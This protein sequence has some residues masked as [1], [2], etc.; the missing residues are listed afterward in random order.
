MLL[1]RAFYVRDRQTGVVSLYHLLTNYRLLL[2]FYIPTGPHIL[3]LGGGH[4]SVRRSLYT[5]GSLLYMQ[6]FDPKL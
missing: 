5:I 2:F 6:L 1:D 4:V 3:L